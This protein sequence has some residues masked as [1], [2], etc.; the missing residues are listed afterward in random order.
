MVGVVG[1]PRTN[2]PVFYKMVRWSLPYK[3]TSPI[4][5]QHNSIGGLRFANLTLRDLQSHS[6]KTFFL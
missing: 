3:K 6:S 4:A 5:L 1:V 2:N